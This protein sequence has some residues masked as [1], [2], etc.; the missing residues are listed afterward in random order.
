MKT[1]R[2]ALALAIAFYGLTAQAADTQKAASKITRDA[3]AAVL[4]ELPFADQQDFE[5]AKR[6]FVATLTPMTIKDAKGNISWDLT[7][8]DF[9][10]GDA[11]DTVNPSLWRIAALNLNNGLF[12]V[13]DRVYQIRGF[14]LSNMTIIEGD[15]GIIVIDPLVTAEVARAG[16]DLYY[17]NRPKKP[18]VAVI[19]THSHADHYGGVKGVTTEED[20]KSGK[21]K[22][23]APE[24]F[25][26]EAVSENVLAGNAMSR[27]TLY[28]YGALLPRSDKGQLDAG[29]GKTTSFGTFTLIPPT[30]TVKKSGET[31]T[32]DG[33]QMEFQMAP[34]TEAP[35][36]FL[37][38]FPQFKLL[39][40]AEDA[41]HTLHNL[42]TLR[43]AQVRDASNWWKTLNTAINKYGD[44]VEVVLAQHHWPTWGKARING[45]LAGQRDMFKYLHDQ[46]LNLANKGYTMTEIAEQIKLPA[47][48]GNQ[49]ANRGYYGSVNHDA[50]AVYQRYL[51]WYDSNPAHLWNLPP[52]EAGK[53]YVEYM[54]GA[55]A[56]ITKAKKSFEA[57][58]YRW[59]AE[60]LS[61][62]VFA[63]PKNQTARNLEADA[64]EQLGYQTENPTWRNEF[65]MGAYELRNGVPKTEGISTASLDMVAAMTPDLLLDYMGIRLNG[66][67]A[68]GKQTLIN[69]QLPDG[70]KYAIEL[71]NGVVIYT[72]GRLF[73]KADATLTVDKL[74]F[75]GLVLGGADLQKEIAGGKAKVDGSVEK[76]S[77][78]FGL[79]DA[80]PP[81]FNI[82]EP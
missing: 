4:K 32:V 23:I 69:W 29:L 66:P 68:D 28:Q 38:W 20:V 51:G 54:G 46:S 19:Y 75:A 63:D 24:G 57:G 31:R 22:I 56:I 11:P 77:E 45:F 42:Y 21:V 76:V 15:T 81:M 82:V 79:L 40:T 78:L 6:G 36:E 47:G 55:D 61:H 80:F 1:T 58:D 30:D 73:P 43:G 26:E 14:D 27:R 8:Y 10:K 41:T 74:G 44:K 5:D 59:T 50:K 12:K 17:Q 64:L 60:V 7:T 3:N 49:W 18:L 33:V 70:G 9:I 52:T 48:I 37:I 62:V 67:K 16:L 13:T 34:G 39:N 53:R 71:R 72:E 35:S 2:I 65:L 25:L